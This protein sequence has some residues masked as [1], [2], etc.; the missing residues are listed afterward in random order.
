[1]PI[2]SGADA[3]VYTIGTTRFTGLA[4]P[5]RGASETCVWRTTV[6]PGSEPNEHSFDREEVLVVIAGSGVARLD[7]T[8]HTITSGDAIVVPAGVRFGLGNP[9]AEPMELI[10]ALPVGAL[11][12]LADG[13]TL[14]PP[15]AV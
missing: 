6:A 14:V 15:A 2:V 13:T 1:M 7:G 11:A 3:P 4:A 8:E 9:H 10:V 5:S 12:T